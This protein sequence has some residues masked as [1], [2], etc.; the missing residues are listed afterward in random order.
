M[1]RNLDRMPQFNWPVFGPLLGI[2]VTL[3]LVGVVLVP[4]L[5][6]EGDDP[7]RVQT[8]T[9]GTNPDRNAPLPANPG[10]GGA[11]PVLL[12]PEVHELKLRSLSARVS[13]A[14]TV[15]QGPGTQY[16]GLHQLQT[17]EEV[18]VIACSPGCEWLR[19]LSLSDAHAQ[20]WVPAVFLTVSG[21]VESLPVLTPQ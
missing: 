18:H 15:R 4:R 17:G 3:A 2:I 8:I 20:W 6:P 9:D 7:T 16:P 10:T 5:W 21:R 19:I 12:P 13:G 11:G 14:P 1:A